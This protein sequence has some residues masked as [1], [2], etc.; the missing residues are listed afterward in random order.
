MLRNRIGHLLVTL[1]ACSA[2]AALVWAQAPAEARKVVYT[3][4]HFGTAISEHTLSL[5]DA[6]DHKLTQ[7][8]RID[9]MRSSA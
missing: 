3:K 7:L 8:F 4:A 2:T 1:L 6:V 5:D 9:V